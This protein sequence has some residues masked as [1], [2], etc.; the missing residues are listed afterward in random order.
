M[1]CVGFFGFVFYFIFGGWGL[2][3]VT[4]DDQVGKLGLNTVLKE[5]KLEMGSRVEGEE[6]E[7]GNGVTG[8]LRRI[9]EEGR[10]CT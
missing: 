9:L 6:G 3:F 8:T 10:V 4:D 1:R 2:F 7:T 5:E